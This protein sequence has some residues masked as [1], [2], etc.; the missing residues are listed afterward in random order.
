MRNKIFGA[1][2]MLWGGAILVNWFLPSGS[3]S[4]G[5]EAYQ[6]G[7]VAGRIFGGVMLVIGAYYLFKKPASKKND[8]EAQAH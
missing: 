8:N 1:I 5:N 7:Q 4:G 3:G 2:G 6:A